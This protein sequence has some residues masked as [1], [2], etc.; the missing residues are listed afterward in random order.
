M[1]QDMLEPCDVHS[2]C[3][4]CPLPKCKYDDSAGYRIWMRAKAAMENGMGA[5]YYYPPSA[6][7]KIAQRNRIALSV[8]NDLIDQDK[9]SIITIRRLIEQTLKIGIGQRQMY[10]MIKRGEIQRRSASQFPPINLAKLGIRPTAE[11]AAELFYYDDKGLD[12]I[13]KKESMS[14]ANLYRHIRAKGC[15]I[16]TMRK[17][18]AQGKEL[19]L[20][21]EAI[22]EYIASGVIESRSADNWQPGSIR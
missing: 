14:K 7:A 17:V 8:L 6:I 19:G 5:L 20:P 15:H 9:V 3:L 22:K 1:Y 21:P 12:S 13:A 2:D 18:Y 16:P 4:Q 11:V 10:R